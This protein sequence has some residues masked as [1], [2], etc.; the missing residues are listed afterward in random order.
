MGAVGLGVD[1]D[2]V[3]VW[4]GVGWGGGAGWWVS[5]CGLLWVVLFYGFL[6][7]RLWLGGGYVFAFTSISS[8]VVQ[9]TSPAIYSNIKRK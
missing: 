6:L 1:V 2:A 8:R 4:L 5:F 3:V 9:H 7:G